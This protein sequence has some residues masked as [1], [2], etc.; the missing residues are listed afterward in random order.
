[1]LLVIGLGA[2]GAHPYEFRRMDVW[3]W[4]A[5]A[6]LGAAPLIGLR[7]WPSLRWLLASIPFWIFGNALDWLLLVAVAL[8]VASFVA[9]ALV[10]TLVG[11][12]VRKSG[13][14]P[15]PHLASGPL[16]PV[17]PQICSGGRRSR[18]LTWLA[19]GS[20]LGAV[21]VF[22]LLAA[23]LLA[24]ELAALGIAALIMAAVFT[25]SNWFADRVRV[26]VDEVGVH[27]RVLFLEHTAK[28]TDISGLR[29]RYL[30]MPAYGVRLV[31]YVVES[32]RHEVAFPSSM[33]GARE[34]QATIESATGLT[35]PE[36]EIT[37]TM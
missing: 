18:P 22:A 10:P 2:L 19:R 33:Q 21:V 32:P 7:N 4:V 11:R 8:T 5:L 1:M 14:T 34:L 3:G 29:L 35:W 17:S 36:P 13:R 20:C 26:R 12:R 30:F 16:V 24:V 23:G 25:F 31:Y 15:L 6:T 28:W 9:G 27:G 37:P